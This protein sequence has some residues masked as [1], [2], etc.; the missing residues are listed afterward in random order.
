[1]SLKAEIHVSLDCGLAKLNDG[2]TKMAM[3]LPD[4]LAAGHA[5]TGQNEKVYRVA[6][7]LEAKVFEF[8]GAIKN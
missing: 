7:K 1:V 6:Q 3:L 8:I 4:E 2:L 5:S